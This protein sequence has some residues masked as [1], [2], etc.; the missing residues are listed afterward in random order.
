MKRN[1]VESWDNP[2]KF[3]ADIFR[4][5]F[6]L[7]ML[8]VAVK[9]FRMGIGNEYGYGAFAQSLIAG[10]GKLASE[11]PNFILLAYGYVLPALELLIGL[12]LLTKKK[13]SLAYQ[14][15]ALVYLSFVFGQQYDGNTSKVGTEYI[16][17]I[18]ALIAGYYLHREVRK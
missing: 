16:P 6:G 5:T 3:G 10:D 9:K 15:L 14:M 18:F 12:M 8:L 13:V 7:L 17:S 11:A 4:I 1:L 2:K